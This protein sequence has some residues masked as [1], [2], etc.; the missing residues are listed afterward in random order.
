M[1]SEEE[2]VVAPYTYNLTEMVGRRSDQDRTMIVATVE[3]RRTYFWISLIAAAPALLI[4]LIL[5][6][7]FGVYSVLVVIGV[8][9]GA[10]FLFGTNTR[11]GLK[12]KQ[13]E[14]LN[15]RRHAGTG[16]VFLCQQEVD[17]LASD[18]LHVKSGS[19]PTNVSQPA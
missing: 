13:W 15:D 1:A 10:I 19:V 2:K 6:P 18:I 17:P 8:I 16:K 9:A 11:D 3:V 7:I 12:V 5:S 14:A 4:A